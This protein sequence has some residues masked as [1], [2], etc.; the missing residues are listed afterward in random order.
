[1]FVQ[2]KPIKFEI[3]LEE[4]TGL[5]KPRKKDIILNI[6][7]LSK[8]DIAKSKLLVNTDR[9]L[10]IGVHCRDVVDLA[11]LNLS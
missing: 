4:R 1:V 6:T 5:A 11:M 3:A 8:F 7:T 10:G 9:G 2:G